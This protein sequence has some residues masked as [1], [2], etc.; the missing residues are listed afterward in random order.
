[1]TRISRASLRRVVAA[2]LTGAHLTACYSW[3]SASIAPEQL[4]RD[5]QPERLRVTLRDGRELTLHRPMY[6]G[7]SLFGRWDAERR[8]P[9]QAHAVAL[10]D[11]T[12]VEIGTLN[13]A[14]TYFWVGYGLL[15]AVTL[16]HCAVGDAYTCQ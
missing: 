11:I 7:D 15:A 5:G 16:A 9:A 1:M 4:V 3:K 6:V 14:Q 10:D 13:K 8:S 2:V 12:I